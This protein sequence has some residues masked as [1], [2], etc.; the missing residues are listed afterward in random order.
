MQDPERS[1][2]YMMGQLTG[3]LAQFAVVIFI[4]WLII[5]MLTSMGK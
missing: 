2:A 3:C 1:N 5:M 4:I